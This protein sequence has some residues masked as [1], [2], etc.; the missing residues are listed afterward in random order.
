M[1]QRIYIAPSPVRIG[2]RPN[3]AQLAKKTNLSYVFLI[4]CLFRR[5]FEPL[6][7]YPLSPSAPLCRAFVTGNPITPAPP[8]TIWY[9]DSC[10]GLINQL[11]TLLSCIGT[12]L[13][14]EANSMSAFRMRSSRQETRS[15]AS[16]E[17]RPR[18]FSVPAIVRWSRSGVLG[19]F[20]LTTSDLPRRA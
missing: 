14:A 16:S 7:A 5:A 17:S 4:L 15:L 8:E 18:L 13:A 12:P 11:S 10:A 1:L 2:L 20:A 9:R 19:A 3:S 6:S